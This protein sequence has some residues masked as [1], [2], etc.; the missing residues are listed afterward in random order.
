MDDLRRLC[1]DDGDAGNVESEVVDGVVE[2]MDVLDDVVH[3]ASE[4]ERGERVRT[5]V[6]FEGLSVSI[7]RSG[8]KGEDIG[9]E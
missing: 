8:S 5:S 9:D 4:C 1:D 3:D 6:D 7:P 2:N